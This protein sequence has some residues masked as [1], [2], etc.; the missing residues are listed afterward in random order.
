MRPYWSHDGDS[1]DTHPT[2]DEARARAA[3]ALT[4]YRAMAAAEREWSDEVERIAWGTVVQRACVV[5]ETTDND[6]ET[7]VVDYG[8]VDVMPAALRD[9]ITEREHQRAKWG[10]AHDDGHVHGAI[11]LAAAALACDGTDGYVEH[12]DGDGGVNFD[13]WGLVARYGIH[14]PD[15]DDRRK[16]V[17]AAALIVAEVERLDRA[18]A[19]TTPT[20]LA[21][22]GPY[23]Y[24]WPSGRS[25]VFEWTPGAWVAMRDQGFPRAVLTDANDMRLFP[26]P[27]LA[28]SA[29]GA[30]LPAE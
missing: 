30:R 25:A 15:R 1:F 3:D 8:L 7:V 20:T 19:T 24:L 5:S 28:A 22:T 23:T 9:V 18:A 29:L 4:A 11:R 13:P 10:D 21:R 17:I 2:A 16:L 14:G 12:P 26:S 27:T 6:G